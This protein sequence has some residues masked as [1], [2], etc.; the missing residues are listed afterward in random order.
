MK[1]TKNLR[2]RKKNDFLAVKKYHKSIFGSFIIIDKHTS[3]YATNIRLGIT[4]IKKFGKSH[5]R[6]RFKRITREAFRL[7][8]PY[9]PQNLDI[10]VKPRFNAKDATMHDIKNELMNL[11]IP[12]QN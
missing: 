9:L 5:E 10:V 12:K 7:S 11:L 2:L 1:F 4:V 3:E 6:N 8:Y